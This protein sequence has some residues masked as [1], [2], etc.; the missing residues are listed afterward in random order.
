MGL[1]EP[2]KREKAN[3]RQYMMWKSRNG[4]RHA[5][6]NESKESKGL[7]GSPWAPQMRDYVIGSGKPKEFSKRSWEC[8]VKKRAREAQGKQTGPRRPRENKWD[9]RAY[10]WCNKRTNGRTRPLGRINGRP[11]EAQQDWGKQLHSRND[12]VVWQEGVAG[13]RMG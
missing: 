2:G 1:K 11:K 8:K 3:H 7:M 9:T 12:R 6:N 10:Q 13:K 5:Q 4:P